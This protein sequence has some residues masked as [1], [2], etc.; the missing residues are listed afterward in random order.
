MKTYN[1]HLAIYLMIINIFISPTITIII[2]RDNISKLFND[3]DYLSKQMNKQMDIEWSKI[4]CVIIVS[5]YCDI[6]KTYSQYT[7]DM[8]Y[9][10]YVKNLKETNNKTNK[11]THI[12]NFID[13][14]NKLISIFTSNL[15][16]ISEIYF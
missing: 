3:P 16:H 7:Y 4:L 11:K 8:W 2:F 15:P 12:Y 1:E 13:Q 6:V 10:F 5:L 14:T 9:L